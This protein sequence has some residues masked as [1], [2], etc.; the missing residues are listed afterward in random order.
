VFRRRCD[1]PSTEA[2]RAVKRL[3]R[4]AFQQ[5][6]K[7]MVNSLAG[8]APAGADPGDGLTSE[9]VTAALDSIGVSATA[10]AEELLPPQ[11]VEL[12][13]VLGWL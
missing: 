4:A 2:Y 5:R 3:V 13:V 6:R 11:F 1:A 9:R 8:V 10:R 7:M 12:A